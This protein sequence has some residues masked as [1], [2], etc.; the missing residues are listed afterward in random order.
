MSDEIADLTRHMAL[1]LENMKVM[2]A[3]SER[4]NDDL[5]VLLARTLSA[6]L[7]TS[8]AVAS[9]MTPEFKHVSKVDLP[10]PTFYG[11]PDEDVSLWLFS[12]ENALNA[13]CVTVEK[14]KIAAAV[15]GLHD[16]AQAWARELAMQDKLPQDWQ[17]FKEA[18]LKEF[19]RPNNQMFLRER[20][21]AL[22]QTSTV[23]D[24]VAKFRNVISQIKDMSEVDKILA[25]QHALKPQVRATVKL[26]APKDVHEAIEKALRYEDAYEG[27]TTLSIAT[28]AA[29][30]DDAM[31]V[32]LDYRAAQSPTKQ[33]SRGFSTYRPAEPTRPRLPDAE[34]ERLLREGRCFKCGEVGHTRRGCLKRTQ[35]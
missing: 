15:G 18:V 12:L 5:Q 23:S 3:Q 17:G 9:A 35:K 30:S 1:M 25:F 16:L 11:K 24:L 2:Y 34:H 33:T 6:P 28:S 4:R 8:P 19:T 10:I 31:D 27:T 20:L 32:S 14:A 13:R 22:Q 26:S 29:R 7:G 21:W